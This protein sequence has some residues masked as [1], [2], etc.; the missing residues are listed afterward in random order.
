MKVKSTMVSVFGHSV[1]TVD[2]V[3]LLLTDL[4][5]FKTKSNQLKGWSKNDKTL[6]IID[7]ARFSLYLEFPPSDLKRTEFKLFEGGY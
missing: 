7:F 2:R 6:Q 3:K 4:L 5:T 1:N